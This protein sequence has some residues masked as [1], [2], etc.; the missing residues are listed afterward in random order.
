MTI[1]FHSKSVAASCAVG[2]RFH[3]VTLTDRD[4]VHLQNISSP[5]DTA[6]QK[7]IFATHCG[8]SVVTPRKTLLVSGVGALRFQVSFDYSAPNV[9]SIITRPQI[10]WYDVETRT[11]G[12]KGIPS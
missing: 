12:M 2:E 1:N 8:C 10:G 9:T 7:S 6:T 3:S 4:S 5:L 11:S